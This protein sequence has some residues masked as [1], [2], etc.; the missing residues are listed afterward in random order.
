[1]QLHIRCRKLKVADELSN[2]IEGRLTRALNRF[3]PRI[4]RIAVLMVDV[5]GPKGGIDKALRISVRLSGCDKVVLTAFGSDLP[6]MIDKA[7]CR[8]KRRVASAIAKA[9]HFDPRVS[10]RTE[11]AR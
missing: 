8:V 4:Q 1:M 2:F 7:A 5:N 11:L 6:L 3:E 9:R 10:I